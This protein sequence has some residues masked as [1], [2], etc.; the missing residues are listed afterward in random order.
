[1]AQ[2]APVSAGGP[3]QAV[4][5]QPLQLTGTSYL[6]AITA[7]RWS[8]SDGTI[9]D[10]LTVSKTFSTS[11]SYTATLTVTDTAG[12]TYS[13][14]TTVTVLTSTVSVASGYVLI[15]GQLVPVASLSGLTGIPA[16]WTGA[17]TADGTVVI[18][19]QVYP[20]QTFATC[21]QHR[22]SPYNL[23]CALP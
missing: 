12:F 9:A 7:A 5:G 3:Y 19:G 11:G 2:T 17:I 8:F 1:D 14:S 16:W 22:Y 13:S 18:N 4:A 21:D 15:N 23:I 10:G 20:G 6:P